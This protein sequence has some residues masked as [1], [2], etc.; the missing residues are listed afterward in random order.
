LERSD[1]FDLPIHKGVVPNEPTSSDER[2]G[3]RVA[4]AVRDAPGTVALDAQLAR[5]KIRARVLGERRATVQLG[6]YILLDRIGSGGMGVVYAA[7]D[8]ELDRKVALKVL[9]PRAGRATDPGDRLLREAR[10]LAKLSHPNVVGIHDVGVFDRELFGE[11]PP[12]L[13]TAART[14]ADEPAASADATRWL[15]I[16]MELVHGDTL[17]TWL[18]RADR[19]P[20]QIVSAMMDAGR[21]LAAAH[22]HGLVHRDFKPDNVMIDGNGR[23]R[24]MDFGLAAPVDPTIDDASSHA[25]A[26]AETPHPNARA[27]LPGALT[28]TPAYM[29]PEQFLGCEVSAA[30]DQFAFCVTLWEAL[31]GARPF[32]GDS[33]QQL[34]SA[35]LDGRVVRSSRWRAPAW[36]RPVVERGLAT[37]PSSRWPSMDALLDGI[38]RGRRSGFRRRAWV[39]ACALAVASTAALGVRELDERRRIAQCEEVGATIDEIWSDA[40]RERVRSAILATGLSYAPTTADRLIPWLDDRAESWRHERVQACFD[41]EVH[42]SSTAETIDRSEWC[43]EHRKDELD[44]LVSELQRADASFV[45]GSIAAASTWAPLALCRDPAELAAMPMPPPEQREEARAAGRDVARAVALRAAGRY[46]EGLE[47]VRGAIARAE[48]IDYEPLLVSA[49]T[50]EGSLLSR[51]GDHAGAEQLL[52]T[53]Y[54][55]AARLGRWDTAASAA[56][57]LATVVGLGQAR[58]AEGLAWARHAE[59]AESHAPSQGGLRASM[60]KGLVSTILTASGRYAEALALGEEQLALREELL[61]TDHPDVAVTLHNL[62]LLRLSIGDRA[63]AR[64]LLERAL[65]IREA[66]LGPDHPDVAATADALGETLLRLHDIEG[67]RRYDERAL[68]IRVAV[69]GRHDAKVAMSLLKLGGTSRAEGDLAAAIA[70]FEEALAMLTRALGDDHPSV[71]VA[72]TSLGAARVAA[73]DVAQGRALLERAVAIGEKTDGMQLGEAE[74]AF[75]LA[76]VVVDDGPDGRRRARELADLALADHRAAGRE[77][78]AR[79]VSTWSTSIAGVE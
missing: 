24:V 3:T 46:D 51:K 75:E 38:E 40:V 13:D 9:H 68:A 52:T 69:F 37:A 26:S 23:V 53:A 15:F 44:A 47:V 8:P 54:F 31:Q 71:A 79:T 4:A 45:Q 18:Q 41:A 76:K 22:A 27:T 70:K 19:S 5:E 29:A 67:A 33:L 65:A 72:C 10:A 1:A 6:R 34:C 43:F 30:A 39:A 63:E 74:A 35:V 66:T 55:D 7:Y 12:W 57:H 77:E 11:Q 2:L 73:G 14:R 61:G 21:G 42:D 16:A 59:M 56:A 20:E 25:G 28:G 36:L 48:V 32:A 50:L 17:T 62:G 58:Y 60:R 78:E 64:A 49:R